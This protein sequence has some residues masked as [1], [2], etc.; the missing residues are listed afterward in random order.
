MK[1]LIKVKYYL[2]KHPNPPLSVSLKDQKQV[3]AF[4]QKHHN[5]IYVETN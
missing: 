4:K 1:N 3:D 5:Y 2:K